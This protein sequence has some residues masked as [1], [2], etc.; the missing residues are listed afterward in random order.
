MQG[1]RAGGVARGVHLGVDTIVVLRM[2]EAVVIEVSTEEQQIACPRSN[3]G[4]GV[5]VRSGRGVPDKDGRSTTAGD[6]SRRGGG[7]GVPRCRLR[8]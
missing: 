2:A 7:R 1:G 4:M 6:G 5:N 8:M 3:V